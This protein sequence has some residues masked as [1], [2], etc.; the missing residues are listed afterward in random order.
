MQIFLAARNPDVCCT[1]LWRVLKSWRTRQALSAPRSGIC[2]FCV[3]HQGLSASIMFNPHP[4]SELPILSLSVV[5][6]GKPGLRRKIGFVSRL[7]IVPQREMGK[8]LRNARHQLADDLNGIEEV[9]RVFLSIISASF[10]RWNK[11][12]K[13]GGGKSCNWRNVCFLWLFVSLS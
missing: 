4:V 2:I 12:P 1:G 10:R 8:L 3:L 5:Q 6:N 13:N 7:R 9:V 11:H